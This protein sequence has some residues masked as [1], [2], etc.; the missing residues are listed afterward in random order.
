MADLRA[1]HDQGASGLE[2]EHGRSAIIDA[3][4][5]RLFDHAIALYASDQGPDAGRG[6]D[7]RRSGATAAASWRPG[8]TSTSCSSIPTKSKPAVVEPF[9]A[10]L[11]QEVLYPL[12]DCG[13]K[14]GHSTRKVDEVFAQAEKEIQTMTALLES[15]YVAGSAALCDSFQLRRTATSTRP[16]TR[17]DTSWRGSRTSPPGAP[18]SET[19]SSTRSPT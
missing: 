12:W 17:R 15:R 2:V 14:V 1:R 18:S 5:S 8:A 6:L 4:I 10:H 3:L 13:L 9:Q 16:T 7:A 11:T 19:R